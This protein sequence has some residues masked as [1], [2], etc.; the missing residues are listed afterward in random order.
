MLQM[1]ISGTAE[2]VS[3]GSNPRNTQLNRYRRVNIVNIKTISLAI[4]LATSAFTAHAQSI[5]AGSA[6]GSYTN[7]FCPQVQDALKTEYFNMSC[8]ES[9]GTGDNVGRVLQKPTDV[10]IGQMDLLAAQPEDVLAKLTIVNP[11]LGLECLYAVTADPSIES[12]SGI[13]KRTPLALPSETSG[14]AL[15]FKALQGLDENLAGLRNVKN[16]GDSLEA[17]N[18]VVSGD[19]A[20]AFF[21]QF[22]DKDNEVF[23]V[24]NKNK[25]S[26]IPMISRKILRQEAGGIKLYEPSTVNVTPQ[27]LL[28]IIKGGDQPSITTTCTNIVLFTGTSDGLTGDAKDDQEALISALGK[29]QKPQGKKWA[30]IFDNVKAMSADALAKIT[31]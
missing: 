3:P 18:A 5:N 13:S 23:K 21:V 27:G 28:S 7:T 10:G 12:L 2:L 8:A 20:M 14:S 31:N 24:A 19:A 17:V 1:R 15:T 11:G 25:L 29:T 4:A 16:Y 26:F 6:S 22:P 30:G 9:K